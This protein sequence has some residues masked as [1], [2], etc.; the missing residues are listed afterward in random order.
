MTY[1]SSRGLTSVVYFGAVTS[2]SL[3]M[4]F[5][6]VA[7]LKKSKT[8][9]H[10]YWAPI[11]GQVFIIFQATN[12][13]I[14]MVEGLCFFLHG[15]AKRY[16]SNSLLILSTAIHTVLQYSFTCQY[17]IYSAS[18]LVTVL[19]VFNFPGDDLC[20]NFIFSITFNLHSTST[21]LHDPPYS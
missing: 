9:L 19:S 8:F 18:T 15:E 21:C 13:R 16:Y 2:C 17:F 12:L 3:L 14:S 4:Q 10:I 7:S 1:W 6:S 11:F 20:I 5:Y